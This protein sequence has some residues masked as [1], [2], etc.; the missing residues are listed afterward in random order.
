V[1][2]QGV[3]HT[4]VKIG[5]AASGAIAN[6]LWNITAAIMVRILVLTKQ[7]QMMGQMGTIA[8]VSSRC[9]SL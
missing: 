1:K 3:L 8:V 2:R 4:T 5:R 9:G 7:L 6:G